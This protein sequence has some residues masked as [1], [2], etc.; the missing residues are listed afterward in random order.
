MSEKLNPGV[1]E[2]IDGE[3]GVYKRYFLDRDE[4]QKYRELPSD[5]YWDHHGQ[6]IMPPDMKLTKVTKHE[7]GA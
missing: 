4:L 5:T 6:P 7:K 2:M 3:Y 1:V